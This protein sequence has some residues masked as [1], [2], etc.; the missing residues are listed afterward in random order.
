M[1]SLNKEYM[2][3]KFH[4]LLLV[5]VIVGAL[6]WG[7]TAFGY[8]LVDMLTTQLN[9]LCQCNTHVDKIVYVLVALAGLRLASSIYTWLPFLGK[10]A[11]PGSLIPLRD[12]KGDTVVEVRVKPNTRVAYWASLPQS[13]DVV[14]KVK[15]AYGN[16][17]NAGVVM[18][19][20]TGLAKLVLNKGT[21]YKVP[22]LNRTIKRHVHYRMLDQEYG[23]VGSVMTKQY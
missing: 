17:S 7:T 11:L 19:D 3:I 12:V 21:A 8:N 22:L 18:S 9:R 16:F 2:M 10:T 13:S 20:E 1:Q 15:D 23:M 6:N 5:L 14:P 4:Q